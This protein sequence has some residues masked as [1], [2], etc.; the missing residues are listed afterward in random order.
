MEGR[1]RSRGAL[2]WVAS[3][4]LGLTGCGGNG[5]N[6]TN[7]SNDESGDHPSIVVSI[8]PLAWAVRGVAPTEAELTVL[9]PAGASEH[10]FELTPAQ[11]AAVARADVVVLTGAGLEPS[12]EAALSAHPSADRA[13]IRF[14]D[15]VK[16]EEAVATDH[17]HAHDHGSHGDDH[18]HDHGPTDPHFWLDPVLMARFVRELGGS[19]WAGDGAAE[20][21]DALARE[22]EAIDAAYADAISAFPR[23]VLV[24]QH[25]AYGYLC[26]RY[27]LEVGAV[28][29][30]MEQVEP[31]PGDLAFARR[32][33]EEQRV[34]AIYVEPQFSASAAE[35]LA[36]VTKVSVLTLD[37]LGDG[38]WP[39]M[40]R[41]NLEA[42]R[43]GLGENRE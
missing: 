26:R 19:A 14:E 10:G 20:R 36:E 3:M 21:A 43:H 5:G 28:L 24:V 12:V 39:A 13:V 15:F 30:P 40:M 38:D 31:T 16:A 1:T 7:G 33:I 6:A 9:V 34:R 35:R 41:A 37:P 25:S 17:D 42:L 22:C 23:R 2:A 4:A 27:G 11:V 18:A 8:P 29:R 32:V